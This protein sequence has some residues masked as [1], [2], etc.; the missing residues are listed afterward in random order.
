MAEADDS[1]G[2]GLWIGGL[3]RGV[4]FGGGHSCALDTVRAR[5][6]RT[7][8]LAQL[9][10]DSDVGVEE[11]NFADVSL[12]SYSSL[13]GLSARFGFAVGAFKEVREV[14]V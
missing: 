8:A 11:V 2:T 13:T 10:A 14:G 9:R 6:E 12:S 7:E 3:K 5:G 1:S 4:G